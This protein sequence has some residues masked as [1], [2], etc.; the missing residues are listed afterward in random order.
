MSA[1]TIAS[2][3]LGGDLSRLSTPEKLNY[4]DSVCDSLGLNKLT[5]PFAFI[6]LNGK[7]VLYATRDC[8]DQLRKIHK[9]SIQITARESINGVYVV[10]AR[11]SLPDG[12]CDESTGAVALEHL[13]GEA[14]ANAYLKCE[15]KAKRRVTLSICGLGLL[16]ETEVETIKDAIK[17]EQPKVTSSGTMEQSFKDVSWDEELVDVGDY[18]A[19]C[20]TP[21]KDILGKK[22]RDIGVDRVGSYLNWIQTKSSPNY[23]LDDNVIEFEKYA[24]AFINET[25]SK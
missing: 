22:L 2:V 7:E 18:V 13:K 12:R 25:Y 19:K 8:A 5:K 4:Y 9:V 20:G 24:T 1:D 11:G 16:D 17:V 6:K 14:L 10:T 3:V 21:G 23:K 15:T